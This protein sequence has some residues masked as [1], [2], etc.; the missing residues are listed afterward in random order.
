MHATRSP[1]A[2]TFSKHRLL[3]CA[4]VLLALAISVWVVVG[5][6][7]VY[8]SSA[9]LWTD[10]A[11]PA[12]S[13]LSQSDPALRTP[14][15]QSQ[16]YLE[17]LLATRD[18]RLTVGRNSPLAAYVTAHPSSGFGPTALLSKIR[19]APSVDD[20]LVSALGS[21]NVTSAAVGPE[22]LSI[23]FKGP[24][25]MVA[26]GTLKVLIADFVKQANQ[27]RTARDQATL[28]YYKS[29]MDEASKAVASAQQAVASYLVTHPLSAQ[30]DPALTPLTQA[31]SSAEAQLVNATANYDQTFDATQLETTAT[32]RIIDAPQPPT[33]PSG[34]KKKTALAIVAG[35]FAGAVVSVVGLALLTGKATA[36]ARP[37]EPTADESVSPN[38]SGADADVITMESVLSEVGRPKMSQP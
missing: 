24:N 9:S 31:A 18:F 5:T 17:E 2:S 15:A 8:V 36:S 32:L 30:P 22:V 10:N 29:L 4:P 37:Q 33:G 1:Y 11:P 28:T 21:K 13:A 25:P 38:G 3:L 23:S 35:L 6:P 16:L 20:R 19:H 7:K 27:D 26:E 14:A 34:G 12:P